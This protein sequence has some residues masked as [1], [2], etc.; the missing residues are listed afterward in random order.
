MKLGERLQQTRLERELT[1]QD[2]ATAMHVSRQTISNWETGRTYPDIDSLIGLSN[3]FDLSLDVLLKEDRGVTDYLKRQ[4]VAAQLAPVSKLSTILTY[5]ILTVSLFAPMSDI[6]SLIILIAVVLLIIL[7]HRLEKFTENV[8]GVSIT[9]NHRAFNWP[10]FRW[11]LIA[12]ASIVTIVG[13]WL[14]IHF[15][16]T[17]LTLIWIVVTA[18]DWLLIGMLELLFRFNV[19]AS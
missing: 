6:W 17:E 9:T 3:Y 16:Q 10:K 19:F 11:W 12:F 5:L 15:G 18:G 14:Y 13:I 8:T 1:Q 2:L 4:E 7:N